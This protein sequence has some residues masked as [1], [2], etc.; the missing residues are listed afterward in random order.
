MLA[1]PDPTIVDVVTSKFIA[2]LEKK[3]KLPSG[4]LDDEDSFI[5]PL[6]PF[7]H[8][9]ARRGLGEDEHKGGEESKAPMK[10]LA[11]LIAETT[12]AICKTL[13]F[14]KM[15]RMGSFRRCL[16]D[17]RDKWMPRWQQSRRVQGGEES[18]G[19]V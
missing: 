17:L 2:W 12:R 3:S 4:E 10:Q 19:E 14:W 8:N 11:L 18:D 9:T 15:C 13:H 1:D 16:I 6:Y 7:L 5:S